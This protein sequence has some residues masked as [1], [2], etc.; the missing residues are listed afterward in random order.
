MGVLHVFKIIQM[1]QNR[2]KRHICSKPWVRDYV[3][4]VAYNMLTAKIKTSERCR[5]FLLTHSF[6]AER[7]PS[8]STVLIHN[9]KHVFFC[10][11]DNKMG[12]GETKLF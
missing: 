10:C 12:L 4:S 11:G 8:E 2:A 9:F 7:L 6:S 5:L 3:L 1:V